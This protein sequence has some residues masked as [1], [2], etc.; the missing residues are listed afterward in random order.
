[1]SHYKSTQYSVWCDFCDQLEDFQEHHNLKEAE[2]AWRRV[3]WSKK[4]GRWACP[5]CA[6][7]PKLPPP[8][9]T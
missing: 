3:G 2:K 1:M 5:I 6:Y 4:Q 9:P 7:L 8:T